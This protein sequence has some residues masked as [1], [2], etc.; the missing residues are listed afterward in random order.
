LIVPISLRLQ[1]GPGSG[2]GSTNF[3]ATA[4]DFC[5][6]RPPDRVTEA[7]CLN[8]RDVRITTTDPRDGSHFEWRRVAAR[9]C[10][11]VLALLA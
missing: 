6:F 8:L 4:R 9:N 11:T 1:A 3:L 2:Q 10:N 7:A 5:D